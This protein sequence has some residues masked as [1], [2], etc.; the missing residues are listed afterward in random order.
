MTTPTRQTPEASSVWVRPFAA[1]DQDATR[2]LILTGLGEHFG[3]IDERLNP[4]L[5]DIAA[6]YLA[7]G[8][9]FVVADAGGVVAG[10]GALIREEPGVGRLVRMSVDCR[11]RRRGI[12]RSLVAYLLAEARRRGYRRVVLETNDDWNDAIGL[13]LACG[14]HE[15]GRWDGSVHL[16]CNLV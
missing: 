15:V 4:D 3:F 8:D 11:F 1:T 9:C 6:S 12:G 7:G 5:D 2:W 13:Y 16:A 14:F 10:T